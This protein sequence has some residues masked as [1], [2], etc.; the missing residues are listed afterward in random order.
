MGRA[1]ALT[2]NEAVVRRANHA[3]RLPKMIRRIGVSHCR[4]RSRWDAAE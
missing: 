2:L 4:H 1:M 3:L